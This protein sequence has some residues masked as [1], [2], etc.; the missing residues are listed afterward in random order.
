MFIVCQFPVFI[1]LWTSK[2]KHK[3]VHSWKGELG[4]CISYF[5]ICGSY[6]AFFRLVSLVYLKK[7]LRFKKSGMHNKR[8]S[9]SGINLMNFVQCLA[10]IHNYAHALYCD[11]M[12]VL[13]LVCAHTWCPHVIVPTH[14]CAQAHSYLNANYCCQT[15][16]CS[17]A[18]IIVSTRLC[19]NLIGVNISI[20][21]YCW[22]NEVKC[23]CLTTVQLSPAVLILKYF[24][25][26]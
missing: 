13:R 15:R 16:S 14:D 19:V 9:H 4:S 8:T 12:T 24:L 11:Q 5:L 3:S 2:L 22:R 6:C 7:K 1:C 25:I 26:L 18:I 21:N 10:V 23:D 17:W 20:I